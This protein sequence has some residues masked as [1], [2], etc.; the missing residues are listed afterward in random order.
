MPRGEHLSGDIRRLITRFYRL[1]WSA[2]ET[3]ELLFESEQPNSPHLLSLSHVSNFF[4]LFR[5]DFTDET[6]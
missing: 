5:N 3:W 4:S 6:F 1:N 2:R